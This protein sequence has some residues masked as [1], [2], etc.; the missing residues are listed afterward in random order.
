MP[1]FARTILAGCSMDDFE[2][3]DFD[4]ARLSVVQ[5]EDSKGKPWRAVLSYKAVTGYNPDGTPITKWRQKNKTLRGCGTERS[6]HIAANK[7]VAK[8]QADQSAAIERAEE[9]E[10]EKAEQLARANAVMV[11]DYVDEFLDGY[12]GAHGSIE[13][14]TMRSY[15]GSAKHIRAAF[16]DTPITELAPKMVDG[17]LL[18]LRRDGYSE[19]LQRKAYGLL[20]RACAHAVRD[21]VIAANPLDSVKPPANYKPDPNALTRTSREEL[22]CELRR[23][24]PT[25]IRTAAFIA[26]YMGLRVGEIAAL[27]WSDIDMRR[28]TMHVHHAIGEG[29]GGSYEKAPKTE[30]SNRRLPIPESLIEPLQE[31]RARMKSEAGA[32]GLKLNADEFGRLYVCGGIDGRYMTP[33]NLGREWSVLAENLGLMGTKGRIATFHDLRHTFA[34]VGVAN[35]I[36]V[37]SVQSYLGHANAAVTLNIYADADE[38][39]KRAAAGAIDAAMEPGGEEGGIAG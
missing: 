37:K 29:K 21:H 4:G 35:G 27:R 12:R 26:L 22:V 25:P 9:M 5:R 10:R 7:W 38:D 34:T 17:W 19:S 18:E 1:V 3:I 23:F 16:A 32:A 36:D 2:R 39:A 28:R 11:A 8:L 15:R 13:P 24:R 31:R 6:A 30:S 33:A 20:Q 14:S